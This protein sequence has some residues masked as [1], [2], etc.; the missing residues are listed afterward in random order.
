[1]TEMTVSDARARLADAVD[2]ARTS[3]APIYLTRRG[4]RIAALIGAEDLE[5]LLDAADDLADIEA[6]RLAREEVAES[7]TIPWAKVRDDLG[8]A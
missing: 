5:R 6:S 4:R 7:G 8:L 3:H 1:M 2:G